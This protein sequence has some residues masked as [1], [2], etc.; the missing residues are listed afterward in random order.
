MP[1]HEAR[2]PQTCVHVIISTHSYYASVHY[3][4]LYIISAFCA[5][6]YIISELY[7]RFYIIS[8]L[9]LDYIL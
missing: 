7:A 9:K 6:L 8:T 1:N 4:R 3:A 2:F 5:R